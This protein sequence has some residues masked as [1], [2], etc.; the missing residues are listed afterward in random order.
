MAAP[1]W[2]QEE[3]PRFAAAWGK[4]AT[5]DGRF[6]PLAI[7]ANAEG[8]VYVIH[9]YQMKK[10]EKDEDEK[11]EN[12]YRIRKF[13][14]SGKFLLEWGDFSDLKRHFKLPTGVFVDSQGFV[15]TSD[16]QTQQVQ[17]CTPDGK[18]VVRFGSKG[19]KDGQSKWLLCIAIGSG[20][21]LFIA[22][23]GNHC[24][25]VLGEGG[26]FLRKWGTKGDE[27]GQLD[28]PH[29]ITIDSKGNL[30]VASHRNTRIQKFDPQGKLLLRWDLPEPSKSRHEPTA[31]HFDKQDRLFVPDTGN[32][33][34]LVYDTQG[35]LL[36]KFGEQGNGDG[37]FNRPNG[38][39]LDNRGFLYVCDS[40]NQR[41]QKFKLQVE[42]VF[43]AR[44]DAFKTLVNPACSY[45]VTEAK[46]RAGEL[47]S[48]DP[49][50]A[51]TRR[52][53]EGGA[54][55]YRFFL[56]PYR[57]I[58]DSYG[59]F[60]YDP[61]AG[62]ARG[63]TRSLDFTFHGWRNGIMVMKHKDGTLFSTLSGRAFA[64]P[65]KGQQ[66][67]AI[68]T[69]TTDW[70]YWNA[71]YPKSVAYSMFEKYQPI[72][73][74]KVEHADSLRSRGP[75]DKRLSGNTQVIGVDYAGKSKVYP[76]DALQK[77]GGLITDTVGGKPIVVLWYAPTRTA[78]VY[79]P[80]VDGTKAEG[81][82]S[83]RQ[84][85]LTLDKTSKLSPFVDR[86]TRSRWGIEGRAQ[87]GPLKGRTLRWVNSVQCRWF[88]W[89]A[90]YPDTQLYSPAATS[91]SGT[92]E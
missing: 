22:G 84:V 39:A 78:A 25:Q 56:Q 42:P 62:F 81:F 27:P 20:G 4:Q 64:G 59:V 61:D 33:R 68:P 91:K 46:R 45:C 49:V 74:P 54:I 38:L 51:W 11:D 37:Q 8:E 17:K 28:R 50:L 2:A 52:N 87:S 65:R 14:S 19:V 24:I 76:L 82:K 12:R 73:L 90:D 31:I 5:P 80:D 92:G 44:P 1:A 34:I 77:A 75:A 57:V 7:A 21:E 40:G 23:T 43:I 58:S 89:S 88:A 29:A 36:M 72:E 15:Y 13:D 63:F 30:Y 41:I 79:T 67:R 85:T 6:D 60:V 10:A 69:I 70:G 18:L 86:Q 16:G 47:K 53:H 83:T 32:H 26:K 9:R 35:K 66:L 55:P 48:N 3:A 71:T